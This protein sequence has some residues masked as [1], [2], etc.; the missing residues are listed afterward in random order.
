MQMTSKNLED[1]LTSDT[2]G[3]WRTCCGGPGVGGS[4]GECAEG[5]AL[6]E[7]PPYNMAC[8]YWYI[9]TAKLMS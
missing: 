2:D 4:S 6:E 7:K 3:G 8:Q 5:E 1:G 9:L